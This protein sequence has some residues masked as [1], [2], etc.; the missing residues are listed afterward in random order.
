MKHAWAFSLLLVSCVWATGCATTS[1]SKTNSPTEAKNDG[2]VVKPP[3]SEDL[4]SEIKD[5]ADAAKESTGEESSDGAE[6]TSLSSEASKALENIIDKAEKNVETPGAKEPEKAEKSQEPEPFPTEVNESVRKWITYFSVNDKERFQ[7]FLDR[8][9]RYR[10]VVQ[11]ILKENDVPP[12]LY[13][14]AM[15]ESGYSTHAK[16]SAKAV[17]VWQFMKA[18][19]KRYDLE[20]SHYVDERRDPIRATEAAAKYLTDLYNAFQSW[21]LAMAAYN[22]GEFRVLNAIL[23]GKSRDYWTLVQKKKIPPETRDY[24]PKFLAAVIIGR[25]PEKYGFKINEDDDFPSVEAV[26]LPSPIRLFDVAQA[27][28]IPLETLKTA[29]PHILRGVTTPSHSFYEVWVPKD[30]VK[31]VQSLIPK[32]ASARL[33]GIKVAQASRAVADDEVEPASRSVHRVRRGE[34]LASIARRYHVSISYL[35]RM[36][37]LSRSRIIVG[38]S[39]RVAAKGYSKSRGKDSQSMRLS[40]ASPKRGSAYTVRK[41]DSLARIADFYGV[42]IQQLKKANRLNSGKIFVGQSLKLPKVASR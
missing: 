22:S 30:K 19:G 3:A 11:T 25:H 36:N 28:D 41:G 42:T 39:L 27:A 20:V 16:S 34:T 40:Q 33:K 7:R 24:V 37:D 23:A 10:K 21:Y 26:N 12:E 9:E 13:Y 6:E 29:N 35:K 31:E 18:T 38:Q 32:F 15:I 8:G 1:S 4:R 2:S 14:L 17:G 5:S